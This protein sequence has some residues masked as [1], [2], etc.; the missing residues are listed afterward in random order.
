MVAWRADGRELYYLAADRGVMA[1]GVRTDSGF[2][3]GKPRLLFKAPESIPLQGTPGGLA[4]IARD[5][6]RFLFAVPPPPPPRPPLTRVSVLDRQGKTLQTF[7]DPGRYGGPTMS[8]DASRIAVIKTFENSDKSEIW[9]FDVATGKGVLFAGGLDGVNGLLWSPDGNQLYYVT[10]RTGGFGVLLR[11]RADGTGAEEQ[12]YRHTPG[13]PLNVN[14]ISRDGKFLT[15]VSGGVIF[16]LPLT[17]DASARKPVE[18]LRDEYNNNFGRF[19]PDGRSMAYISNESGRQELWVRPFDP[20]SL[21]A[22]EQGKQKLTT[23][24]ASVMVSWRADGRELYYR[25]GDLSDA[26]NIAVDATPA[27]GSQAPTP[28]YLFRAANTT[29]GASNISADGQRFAVVTSLPK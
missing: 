8:P 25:L 20:S 17:G 24:G 13:A 9:V 2:E 16:V 19:S 21:V 12:V 27:A 22:S 28:R 18:W 11:K 3:F 14:D 15:F 23:N 1:V 29:G 10:T 26:L 4:S 6:E 5:G 7:G